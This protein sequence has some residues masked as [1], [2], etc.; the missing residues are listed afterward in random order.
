MSQLTFSTE[1]TRAPRERLRGIRAALTAHLAVAAASAAILAVGL[2]A[3]IAGA[4]IANREVME[5]LRQAL[6]R[7]AEA[8]GMPG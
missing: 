6:V 2:A 3:R 5:A 4:A 1:F 8:L 7:V